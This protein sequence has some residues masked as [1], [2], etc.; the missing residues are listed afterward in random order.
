MLDDQQTERIKV[1]LKW[2]TGELGPARDLDVYIKTKIKPSRGAALAK[3]GLRE[4]AGELAG[5]RTAAFENA[6]DAV[7]SPRYR[8][9]MLN[10]LQWIE[11]ENWTKRAR[12]RGDRRVKKFAADIFTRRTKRR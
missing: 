5:R 12:A 1:E 4:F 9:L 6:K 3:R 10:T 2:L 11:T 7:D 8:S